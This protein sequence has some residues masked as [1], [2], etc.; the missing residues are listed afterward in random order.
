MTDIDV[1][2]IV[3][4]AIAWAVAWINVTVIPFYR[5]R[6][7]LF[8]DYDHSGALSVAL[9]AIESQRLVEAL[10]GMFDEVL[11]KQEDRRRK[12]DIRELLQS[13]EFLPSFEKAEEAYR[14][15]GAIERT[16]AALK[17]ASAFWKWGVVHVLVTL[18]VPVACINFSETNAWDWIRTENMLPWLL[19]IWI[20]TA[21]HVARRFL[22][23]QSLMVRFLELLEQANAGDREI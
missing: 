8:K 1:W 18:L 21:G 5:K 23:F 2:E 16:Y 15:M 10:A 4:I 9:S 20:L 6:E 12:V 7:A 22:Q 14:D 19:L 17:E 11:N 3:G 13:T